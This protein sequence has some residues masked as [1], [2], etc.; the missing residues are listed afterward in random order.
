MLP[1]KQLVQPEDVGPAVVAL[2]ADSGFITGETIA[3]DGA[4]TAR[5]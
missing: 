3:V 2:A 1:A 4:A 5:V